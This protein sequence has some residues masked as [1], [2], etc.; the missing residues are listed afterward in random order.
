M[1]KTSYTVPN[2]NKKRSQL[3]KEWGERHE[4]WAGKEQ[5]S[6]GGRGS[7]DQWFP[8]GW[9]ATFQGNQKR[10]IPLGI[11]SSTIST[12]RTHF[13]FSAQNQK[14]IFS[15]KLYDFPA[16]GRAAER[17]A[18]SP[19]PPKS[20][21]WRPGKF[22][23]KPCLFGSSTHIKIDSAPNSFA[24]STGLHKG[25]EVWRIRK[26][27]AKRMD[28]RSW[29]EK[30]VKQKAKLNSSWGDQDG[31]GRICVWE[32]LNVTCQFIITSY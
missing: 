11:G 24:G 29:K 18:G 20:L 15:K 21:S 16:P 12:I 6:W 31:T 3:R 26:R 8:V 27:P 9:S 4:F 10:A 17:V 13:Q 5:R 22:F 32:G 28:G 23:K 7:G 1:G 2:E 14:W 30:G 19:D 25:R